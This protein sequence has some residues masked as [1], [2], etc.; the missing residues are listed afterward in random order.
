MAS[1]PD[2]QRVYLENMTLLEI[3]KQMPEEQRTQ[4]LEEATKQVDNMSDSIKQQAAVSSVKEIYK[5]LGVDTTSC[6]FFC[7]GD[8]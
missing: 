2:A 4:V 8:L 1:V 5:G 6:S 7:K 3:I